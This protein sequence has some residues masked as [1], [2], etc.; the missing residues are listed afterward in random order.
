MAISLP[1]LASLV[2]LYWSAFNLTAAGALTIAFF[3][4]SLIPGAL[5]ASASAVF[6][7]YE[8]MEYPALLTSIAT[9]LRVALGLV[10]LL[11]GFGIAGLGF[12]ALVVNVVIAALFWL[13]LRTT[14]FQPRWQ[15]DWNA[16]RRLAV[17]AFPLMINNFLSSIFFRIDVLFLKPMQGDA[18]TGYYTTAYKFIDGLNI[19]PAFFTLAVFPL[20]SRYAV[21]STESLVFAFM[22]S[23]KFLLTIALPITVLITLVA[24]QIILLF[25]GE[26][27]A[28]AIGALQILIWFLPFSY[29]NS[30]THYVLI[31]LNRQR[32]LTFAFLIGVTFNILANLVVIPRFGYLG[33]AGVTVLSEIVLLIPFFVAVKQELGRL[34]AGGLL[35]RPALATLLAS[36]PTALLHGL[37]P[38][39]LLVLASGLLYLPALL[40]VGGIDREDMR[41]LHRLLRQAQP[42]AAAE[43]AR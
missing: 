5:S 31:A 35:L 6:S 20:F 30:L 3:G 29:I 2:A 39:P 17:L 9:L 10:A 24:D 13:L 14:F 36:L 43:P 33:A 1:L 37:A 34:P 23:L 7:A 28:P 41:L 18:A 22:R 4:L 40:L 25:F 42:V 8:K 21:S 27:F 15:V 32:Y 16:A 12:I 19:I 11:S 38:W 26:P